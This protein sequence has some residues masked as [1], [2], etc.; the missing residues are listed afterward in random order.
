MGIRSQNNPIASYLDVFSRSGTDASTNPAAADGLVA[1]GGV[2]S[3]YNDSGTIYRAH[4]FTSSGTFEVT[5][6][7]AYGDNVE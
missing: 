6:S 2:I 5:E 7:G 4:V 3:D 1:T